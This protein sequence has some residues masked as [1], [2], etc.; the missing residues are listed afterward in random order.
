MSSNDGTL[1]AL[2]PGLR[3]LGELAYNLWWSWNPAAQE[4]FQRLDHELW[5][6]S[7][8]NP[9]R[10][11]RAV[12]PARLEQAARNTEFMGHFQQ[13]MRA[14]DRYM[15]PPETWFSETYPG[16]HDQVVAYFSAE[17]GLHE[18][19]PIYSGGLGV[20]SGDHCK[21]A[22]DL[23]LP[24]VGVGFLYPQGY[25]RQQ[26]SAVGEQR[27]IYERLDF[28]T[29]PATPVLMPCGD[30]VLIRV[31]LPGRPVFA[32]AW[33]IQVGRVPVFL[34]DTDV[35]RNAHSDRELVARLYGGDQEIRISQEFVLGVGGVRLLR[36]LGIRPAA[37][38]LNE[39]HAA[40][41]VLERLRELVE[42]EGLS[43]AEAREAVA[44][45]TI[46]TTHTPVP[47]GHD[48]FPFD[49]VLRYFHDYPARLGL[50]HDDFLA[51]GREERPW[52]PV[53]S[54]TVLA[55]RLSD[56]RNG[57]SALHGHTARQMWA[58]L[59][60]ERAVEEAPPD[61]TAPTGIT[62]V[63]NG[64]HLETWL[65]PEMG[66]LFDRYLGDGW[67]E[68]LDD[69]RTWERVHQV[70]DREL[71]QVRQVI[72]RRMLDLVARRIRAQQLREGLPV[73]EVLHPEALTIGFARRFATYKRATLIF[74]DLERLRAILNRPGQPVQIIFAGKAHP[75]DEL[76]KA[77]IR[78]VAEVARLEGFIGRVLLVEEYDMELA[79]AM[80]Q[81]VDL[82]LNNPRRPMEASGTSGQKAA[83]NGIP[84]CS[85]L[86]G[87][88]PEAYDGTNGWAIGESAVHPDP[89]AQDAADAASLYALLEDE[90][91][92]LFYERDQ[93]GVPRGWLQVARRAIQTV[94]PAFN[95]RRMVKEYTTRMYRP[96]MV[97]A[98][99]QTLRV[100]E[101]LRVC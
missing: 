12:A 58:F 6:E 100:S 53:F 4:L 7:R 92:P 77:L 9:V 17:F 44:A 80:V 28:S 30:E 8:H 21:A 89:E 46:F 33:R 48:I 32:R 76:G 31:E 59:W 15:Q 23:G 51:L 85:V 40:F 68:R 90:I 5:E 73:D 49:L 27:A 54:M 35:E 96:A 84:N 56:Y 82:W 69:P 29:V 50:S 43:F 91:V 61:L 45:S 41:V 38:H 11:L 19:L 39:G 98:E 66:Q 3:R 55:L 36:A 81:G 20:L 67:R 79:R 22:S 24:L 13:V 37:W 10:F 97:R 65:A 25:F 47:A 26:I 63:T 62:H 95:A 57:V 14:F 83:M 71:W 60:P 87:W 34:M 75:A 93:E 16:P 1:S 74:H 101:T 42:E 70:P 72:K 99:T 2:P 18:S 88:W 94:A 52:G 86:D 78:R 64:V